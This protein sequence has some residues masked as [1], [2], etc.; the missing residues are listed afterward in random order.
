MK[1]A[2]FMDPLAELKPAIDTSLALLERARRLGWSCYY[3]TKKDLFAEKGKIYAAVT[4]IS[5]DTSIV[6][7]Q[8]DP[9]PTVQA[10]TDFDIILIRQDPPFDLGYLYATQ[11]LSLV[12]QQ[13]ILVSN[14]PQSLQQH[15]EKLGILQYPDL[16]VPTL[17]SADIARMKQFWKTHG[18]VI[19]KPLGSMGGDSVIH[20]AED[21]RN[22]TVILQ[23]LTK[24]ETLPIMAQRYIPEINTQGDKRIILINGNPVPYAFARFAAPGESRANLCAGGTGT[25]IPISERDRH[26]CAELGPKLREQ[27]LYFVGIDVIGDYITEINVTSPTCARQIT[28]ETGLDIVGEY[29]IFLASRAKS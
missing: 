21:G 17:V 13:G 2:I 18:S 24:Q 27:S 15:N 10:L 19:F 9:Q 25:V 12:A 14:H 7:Y 28:A 4:A 22:L 8:V 23:W 29:L 1:L 11:L 16:C 20:L 5:V 3:F 26:I 6:S